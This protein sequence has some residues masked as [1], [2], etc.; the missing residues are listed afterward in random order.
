MRTPIETPRNFT[1]HIYESFFGN[2]TLEAFLQVKVLGSL[3][4]YSCIV[5]CMLEAKQAY[6]YSESFDSALLP[7]R[8]LSW[9][10]CHVMPLFLQPRRNIMMATS[11]LQSCSRRGRRARQLIS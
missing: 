6:H 3:Y 4:I 8:K 2:L 9:T 11:I 7:V 5:V 10:R 1:N